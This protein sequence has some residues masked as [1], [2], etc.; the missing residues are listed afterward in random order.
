MRSRSSST[1][2]SAHPVVEPGVL[3]GDAGRQRQGL[4]HGL[5]LV[6]ELVG[7]ALVGQVEVAV[8]RRRGPARD[9]RGTK[10]SEDGVAGTRS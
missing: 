2:S 7:A 5:V 8:D 9:T 3:D 4:G 6:A 1:L 10:S